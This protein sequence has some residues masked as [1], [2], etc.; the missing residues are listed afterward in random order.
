MTLLAGSTNVFSVF[1]SLETFSLA[2]YVLAGFNK[3]FHSNREAALKY[4][5]LGAFGAAFFLFGIVLVYGACGEVSYLGFMQAWQGPQTGQGQ[6]M[7]LLLGLLLVVTAFAF[8]IGLAPF[9][10][11]VPDT[12]EGAPTP[13]SAFLSAGAKAAGMA[14]ILRLSVLVM[15]DLIH[16]FLNSDCAS[17]TRV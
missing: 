12:Y 13:V 17:F 6:H 4:F 7:L 8:K 16:P 15:P 9:H 10:F 1:V 3:R 5:L 2:M 11:W 14:A